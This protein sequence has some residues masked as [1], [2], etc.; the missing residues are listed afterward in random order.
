M[1]LATD[2]TSEMLR[3]PSNV[4]LNNEIIYFMIVLYSQQSHLGT[5]C[6]SSV[7]C[8]FHRQ[9]CGVEGVVSSSVHML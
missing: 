4:N 1:D 5:I 7:Q 9:L 6:E 3:Q 2:F 8:H